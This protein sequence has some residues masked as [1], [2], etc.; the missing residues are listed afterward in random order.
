M[1]IVFAKDS[2]ILGDTF[3]VGDCCLLCFWE[4]LPEANPYPDKCAGAHSLEQI[5]L[6]VSMQ[7]QCDLTGWHQ[8]WEQVDG[9][10]K[11]SEWLSF[12]IGSA[13]VSDYGCGNLA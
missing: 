8:S 12:E 2:A 5:H 13:L 4:A 7:T 10:Y 1:A 3:L 9:N 11:I 6:Q